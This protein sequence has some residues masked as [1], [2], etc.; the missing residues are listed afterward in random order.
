MLL[1]LTQGKADMH[2][3]TI[4]LEFLQEQRPKLHDKLRA[5]RM[6]L[7]TMENQAVALKRYHETWMDRLSQA[8][9]DSDQSQNQSKALEL[10][11]EDMRENLP[12]ESAPDDLEPFSL[13]AAMLFIRR[14]TPSA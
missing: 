8:N 10:A 1:S 12:S 7:S 4:V 9:P 2:Y 5:S 14:H 6:L 3:K 13:D 11:L